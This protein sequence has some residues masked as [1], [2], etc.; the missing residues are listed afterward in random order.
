MMDGAWRTRLAAGFCAA[1]W[2]ANGWDEFANKNGFS[3][4]NWKRTKSEKREP[5]A[6]PFSGLK[7]ESGD[8]FSGRGGTF[9]AMASIA[10]AGAF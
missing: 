10:K 9:T 1:N 3:D 6:W 2:M 4:V 5:R 8:G 7:I